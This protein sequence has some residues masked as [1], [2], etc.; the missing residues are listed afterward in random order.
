M[1]SSSSLRDASTT[2]A[3]RRAAIR[4]VTSPIPLDAPVMTMTCSLTDF[5]L[6]G[7]TTSSEVQHAIG[8]RAKPV[9]RACSQRFGW[10]LLEQMQRAA[11]V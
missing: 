4:A 8:E 6:I 7:I 2:A 10:R 3:P 11:F 1:A 5:S 9:A